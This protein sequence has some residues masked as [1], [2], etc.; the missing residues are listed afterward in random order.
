MY[1]SIRLKHVSSHWFENI[2][3]VKELRIDPLFRH[4]RQIFRV[5]K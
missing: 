1:R 4:V 2:P 5:R 3:T